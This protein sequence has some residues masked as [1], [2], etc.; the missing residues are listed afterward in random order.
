M[1]SRLV[2]RLSKTCKF[3]NASFSSNPHFYIFSRKNHYMMD[4]LGRFFLNTKARLF[5]ISNTIRIPS[6]MMTNEIP[7]P[8]IVFSQIRGAF[9]EQGLMTKHVRCWS[10]TMDR[11]TGGFLAGRGSG[12]PP[13]TNTIFGFSIGRR[14][15]SDGD[16]DLGSTTGNR[17]FVKEKRMFLD[18][19]SDLLRSLGIADREIKFRSKFCLNDVQHLSSGGDGRRSIEPEVSWLVNELGFGKKDVLKVIQTSPQLFNMR[20]GLSRMR[21]FMD[22]FL[23]EPGCS[24]ALVK[25]MILRHPLILRYPDRFEPRFRFLESTIGVSRGEMLK[26][27][28]TQPQILGL[29]LPLNMEKKIRQLFEYGLSKQDIKQLVMKYPVI[30]CR[31]IQQHMFDKVDWMCEELGFEKEEGIHMFVKQPMYLISSLEVIRATHSWFMSLESDIDPDIFRKNFTILCLR[32]ENVEKKFNFA[33]TVLKKPTEEI[34]SCASYFTLSL[35]DR[36]M[37]RTWFLQSIGRDVSS[38]ALVTAFIFSNARFFEKYAKDGIVSQK[39]YWDG[40]D[41]QQ[42]YSVFDI[43]VLEWKF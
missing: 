41:L 19:N 5:S 16:S 15:F 38:M 12:F 22:T 8:A 6:P 36:I 27:I 26:I 40:L 39:A 21:A 30:L 11:F 13:P 42:K 25:K 3:P 34:L 10:T 33:K 9:F 17:N 7:S 35:E 37:F 20:N 32:Q 43:G 23:E 31:D 24:K 29:S 1:K 2:D 18:S 4:L 28:L 14:S